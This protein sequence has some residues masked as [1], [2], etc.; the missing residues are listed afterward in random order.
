MLG[1]LAQDGKS[2]IV[3][4][5]LSIQRE[6]RAISTL[7]SKR[8]RDL[9]KEASSYRPWEVWAPTA[10]KGPLCILGGRT[11]VCFQEQDF[12][13]GLSS[14]VSLAPIEQGEVDLVGCIGSGPWLTIIL[15][16][17]LLKQ[18]VEDFSV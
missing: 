17:L 4:P 10:Y 14:R 15:S 5:V 13:W 8:N 9:Q 11:V 3:S 1:S 12:D 7:H 2:S 18:P 6:M 16:P